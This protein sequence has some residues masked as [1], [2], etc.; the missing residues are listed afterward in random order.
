[1]TL[2]HQAGV[3]KE[4]NMSA[5]SSSFRT[6]CDT[7]HIVKSKPI[8]DQSN[9]QNGHKKSIK[10]SFYCDTYDHLIIP[11]PLTPN[12]LIDT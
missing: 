7:Y 8:T 5:P 6:F 9:T 10:L 11:Y 1:M 3:E 2:Y 12:T 4:M